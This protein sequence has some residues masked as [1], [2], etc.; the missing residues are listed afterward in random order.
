[1]QHMQPIVPAVT[2]QSIQRFANNQNEIGTRPTSGQTHTFT[3]DD[4]A[5]LGNLFNRPTVTN[6]QHSPQSIPPQNY[7]S[8]PARQN[9]VRAPQ[10]PSMPV[11]PITMNTNGH[12]PQRQPLTDTTN[13]RP[14]P[15][16]EDHDHRPPI[17][18]NSWKCQDCTDYQKAAPDRG[19][20]QQCCPFCHHIKKA[21][22]NGQRHT[23]P[24][25]ECVELSSCPTS[26]Q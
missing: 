14:P 25:D 5:S 22:H 12:L 4:F 9:T 10:P 21:H 3:H 18:T 2:F 19:K 17:H 16:S 6:Y 24:S 7:P 26:F 20:R 15:I 1:M 13:T 11:R 8:T 23:C